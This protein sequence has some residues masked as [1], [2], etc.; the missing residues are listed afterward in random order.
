MIGGG[1]TATAFTSLC[2]CGAAGF[3][4]A[5]PGIAYFLVSAAGGAAALAADTK[6]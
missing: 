1:E 6:K 4:W 3:D 2:V 5:V